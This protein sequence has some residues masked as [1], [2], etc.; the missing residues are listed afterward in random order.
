MSIIMVLGVLKVYSRSAV[1]CSV[2]CASTGCSFLTGSPGELRLV[3]KRKL[4]NC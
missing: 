2:A 3:P 1:D 4:G